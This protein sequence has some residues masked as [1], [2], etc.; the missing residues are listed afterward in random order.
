MT[1]TLLFSTLECA[2]RERQFLSEG[3]NR[4][5]G[6]RE[7]GRGCIL[8]APGQSVPSVV[9]GTVFAVSLPL[10]APVRDGRDVCWAVGSGVASSCPPKLDLPPQLLVGN[11]A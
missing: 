2:E 6:V 1:S 5:F 3:E 8:A 10:Q 4:G 7:I 11:L 9:G